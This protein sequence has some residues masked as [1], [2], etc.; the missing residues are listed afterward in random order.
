MEYRGLGW[1]VFSTHLFEPSIN[2]PWPW[3]KDTVVVLR[4]HRL[5]PHALGWQPGMGEGMI[6]GSSSSI[7]HVRYIC[8]LLEF[9]L[10]TTFHIC[11]IHLFKDIPFSLNEMSCIDFQ[12][13]ETG[14]YAPLSATGRTAQN[15]HGSS[16]HR[17]WWKFQLGKW[18]VVHTMTWDGKAQNSSV[19]YVLIC[20][21]C[22][23]IYVQ[24]NLV[25]HPPLFP[26]STLSKDCVC[27]VTRMIL[28]WFALQKLD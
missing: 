16:R 27:A 13:W 5:K 2:L 20:L 19:V 23:V 7:R 18:G 4:S 8:V 15:G 12:C 1:G 3:I 9:L 17:S 22:F 11:G 10:N 24:K 21:C 25:S 28:M 6:L 14:E 26:S